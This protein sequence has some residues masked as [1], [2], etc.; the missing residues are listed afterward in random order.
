V[1]A[2]KVENGDCEA[3]GCIIVELQWG[4]QSAANTR[5]AIAPVE[6]ANP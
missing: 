2:E 1:P 4:F 5:N 3:C 6:I